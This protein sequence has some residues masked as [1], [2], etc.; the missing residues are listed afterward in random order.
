MISGLIKKAKS[1]VSKK[2]ADMALSPQSEPRTILRKDHSIS[3]KDISENT[4]K[5]LYRLKKHGFQAHLVGG[6]VRDLLLKKHPKDFDVATDAS[7]E[8]VKQIFSNC[9]LIGKR[10]RLAHVHFGRDIIEVATFRGQ[11]KTT[12]VDA[13]HSKE[14]MILRDNVY[15]TINEDAWRRDFTINALYYNIADFSV[16]DFTGGMKDLNDRRIRMIG[17]AATRFTEDPVRML[18]AIRFASKLD[19]H[20]SKELIKPIQKLNGLINHVPPARLFEEMI[21]M[22]HCGAADKAFESLL[23]YELFEPLF[24]QTY[25][26]IQDSK[27]PTKSLLKEVFQSTDTRIKQG[28]TITPVFIVAALLWHPILKR[29]EIDIKNGTKLYPARLKA[30]ESCLSEQLKKISMPKRISFGAREVWLLQLRMFNRHG[31]RPERLMQEPRFK[32]AYDFLLLRA[33]A[34]EPVKELADW[35]EAYFEGNE[36]E[37]RRLIRQVSSGGPKKRHHKRKT[38]EDAG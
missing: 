7:P 9:R 22:F 10:F 33:K 28:K 26:C 25:H 38:A 14:G 1:L 13:K 6:G 30:V 24:P 16:L 20:L 8:E 4:L 15:G 35:W 3:R 5:V 29:A 11:V 19:F 36:D 12:H 32:A 18:R 27:Y 21:K 23:Q 31:K 37:R 17:D 34:G 2:T